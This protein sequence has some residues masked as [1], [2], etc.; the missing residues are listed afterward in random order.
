MDEVAEAIKTIEAKGWEKEI[1]TGESVEDRY[2]ILMALLPQ[3]RC[4]RNPL[5]LRELVFY[6]QRAYLKRYNLDLGV[7]QY[8]SISQ[9]K[10]YCN[11]CGDKFEC[12]CVI[13]QSYCKERDGH[14]GLP[15]YPEFKSPLAPQQRIF[16]MMR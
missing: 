11:V 10:Q 6:L 7:C 14:N 13:P 3:I 5:F 1:A 2:R 8:Y 15:R 9:G 12:R 16:L 4:W